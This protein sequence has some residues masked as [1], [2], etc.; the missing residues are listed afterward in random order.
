MLAK[1]LGFICLLSFSSYMFMRNSIFC[2]T[3][4]R[5]VG[6]W[7]IVCRSGKASASIYRLNVCGKARQTHPKVRVHLEN[8]KHISEMR[9]L[10]KHGLYSPWESLWRWSAAH[11]HIW[12]LSRL[13]HIRL[14]S[15]PPMETL[16][17]KFYIF[18]LN[19]THHCTTIVTE[20]RHC[21]ISYPLKL[22]HLK[23]RN[24]PDFVL[25]HRRSRAGS[26]WTQVDKTVVVGILSVKKKGALVHPSF[27][28]SGGNLRARY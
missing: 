28:G 16:G 15:S 25:G 1:V 3:C 2:F 21:Q 18:H 19:V 22:G 10:W 12:D 8:L 6:N 4:D 14:Q 9:D 26:H 5:E 13:L 27:Q 11:D 20:D 24:F 23:F 17:S 7:L